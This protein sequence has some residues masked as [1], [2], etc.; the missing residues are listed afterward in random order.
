MEDENVYVLS[1]RLKLARNAFKAS[2]EVLI[3]RSQ[4]FRDI[5]EQGVDISM[6][7]SFIVEQGNESVLSQT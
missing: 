5:T 7:M 3:M 2:F 6:H 4:Y 1:R